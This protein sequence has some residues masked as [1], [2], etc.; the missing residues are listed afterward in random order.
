MRV[1][2]FDDPDWVQVGTPIDGEPPSDQAGTCVA[3]SEDGTILTI[4]S[5]GVSCIVL[6]C[7][8]YCSHDN[9]VKESFL[10]QA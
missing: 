3:I 4:G 5:P 6:L 9:T 1:F 8:G 10:I 7:L 2:R